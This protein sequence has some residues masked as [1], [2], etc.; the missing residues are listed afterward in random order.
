MAGGSSSI[1]LLTRIRQIYISIFCLKT[2]T[3]CLILKLTFIIRPE[4]YGVLW[5]GKGVSKREDILFDLFRGIQEQVIAK[6]GA[7]IYDKF[8]DAI[9][10]ILKAVCIYLECLIFFMTPCLPSLTNMY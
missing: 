2:I 5:C 4:L 10:D 8:E 7:C 3:D 9:D 1:V 6:F